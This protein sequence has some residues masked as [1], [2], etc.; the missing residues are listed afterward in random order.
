MSA[1][2]V[3]AVARDAIAGLL[4]WES[5]A[6]HRT[7]RKW[8]YADMGRIVP[9]VQCHNYFGRGSNGIA[10]RRRYVYSIRGC[11]LQC[12]PHVLLIYLA[13]TAMLAMSC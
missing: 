1:R 13:N 3:N 7:L 10:V 5:K 2:G 9:V 4:H 11:G 6:Q 12:R 8:L